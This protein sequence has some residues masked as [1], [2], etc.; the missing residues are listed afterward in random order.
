MEACEKALEFCPMLGYI[1]GSPTQLGVR[2][3]EDGYRSGWR[4]AMERA[5]KAGQ[6]AGLENFIPVSWVNK[7]L[8]DV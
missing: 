1:D 7:E 3:Q 5:L 6:D 8:E 4:D 2:A